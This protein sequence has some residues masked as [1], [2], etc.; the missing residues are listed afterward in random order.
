MHALRRIL[1][2]I[3]GTLHSGLHLYPSLATSLTSY[4]DANWGGCPDYKKSTFG[5]CVFLG[6]NL[7]LWSSK[8]QPI[9]SHPCS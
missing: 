4:I 2:Y 5:Y 1:C 3:Q 7:L 8:R 9:L 6:D